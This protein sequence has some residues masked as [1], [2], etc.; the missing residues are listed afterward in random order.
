MFRSWEKFKAWRRGEIMIKGAGRGR[1][2]KKKKDIYNPTTQS[3]DWI[4]LAKA[5]S[6][7]KLVGI[8]VIRANGD[9]EVING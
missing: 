4:K 5:K 2:F 7:A 1:C 8:K 9:V 6:L 3:N